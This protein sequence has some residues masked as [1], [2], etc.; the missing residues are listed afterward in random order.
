MWLGAIN[1]NSRKEAV[2]SVETLGAMI[3]FSFSIYDYG[4]MRDY[5]F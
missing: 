4:F 1:F 2:S 5:A 3:F